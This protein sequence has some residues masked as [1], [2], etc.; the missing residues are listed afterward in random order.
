[1]CEP[2][3]TPH[4]FPEPTNIPKDSNSDT[5][6]VDQEIGIVSGDDKNVQKNGSNM[7][8]EQ[9][10]W[11]ILAILAPGAIVSLIIVVFIRTWSR[12]P[13]DNSNEPQQSKNSEGEPAYEDHAN[14]PPPKPKL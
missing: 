7:N 14:E 3:S 6:S 13:V 10:Y 1:M 9:K 5:N 8:H 4:S 12:N 11:S 2:T